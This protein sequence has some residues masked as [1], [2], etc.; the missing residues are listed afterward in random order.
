MTCIFLCAAQQLK[1]GGAWCLDPLAVDKLNRSCSCTCC[2][3]WPQSASEAIKTN[4]FHN[5][6]KASEQQFFWPKSIQRDEPLGHLN[7]NAYH[8]AVLPERV[9]VG[10]QVSRRGQK[11]FVQP[12]I[13]GHF[14][15]FCFLLM[16]AVWQ[17]KNTS[18]TSGM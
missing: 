18:Q 3:W 16:A 9:E 1:V 7:I 6:F 8:Q 12:Q 5:Y 2:I 4:P 14:I 11:K 13:T 10:V 15:N 17:L